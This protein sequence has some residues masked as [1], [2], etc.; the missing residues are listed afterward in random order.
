MTKG[1]FNVQN[2]KA[3]IRACIKVFPWNANHG[4]IGAAWDKVVEDVNAVTYPPITVLCA[5]QNIEKLLNQYE[6]DQKQNY[7]FV[8]GV[9]LIE[10]TIQA[11]LAPLYN[12]YKLA[13]DAKKTKVNLQEKEKE[14]AA[15]NKRIGEVM[16]RNALLSNRIQHGSS[17]LGSTDDY[18]DFV[19]LDTPS[20]Q[21][22]KR[23][24]N[25]DIYQMIDESNTSLRGDTKEFLRIEEEKLKRKR[26]ETE[27][28]K[29]KYEKDL[30]LKERD[31]AIKEKEASARIKEAES[32]MTE[33]RNM[34]QT[35]L[36][37]M[38]VIQQKLN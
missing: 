10:P 7:E 20:K 35:I 31:I 3:L 12:Q 33:T 23:K 5:K 34:S 25:L 16:K 4:E 24:S 28:K 19:A 32:R 36:A 27:W 6:Q 1:N 17:D 30:A 2:I 8:S 38:Q 37:L 26:E 13:M 9:V 11:E 15:E 14:N 18:D 29:V 22:R 21:K